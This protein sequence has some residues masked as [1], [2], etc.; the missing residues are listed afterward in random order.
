MATTLLPEE[1]DNSIAIDTSTSSTLNSYF[2]SGTSFGVRGMV[3]CYPFGVPQALHPKHTYQSRIFESRFHTNRKMS[4]VD[5]FLPGHLTSATS[6]GP[7]AL[8]PTPAAFGVDPA[9]KGGVLQ[10][11]LRS[12]YQ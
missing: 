11:T 2:V 4:K 3:A 9:L 1:P 10:V 8:A 12:A 7:S 6:L 5:I